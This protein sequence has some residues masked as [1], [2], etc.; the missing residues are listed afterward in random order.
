MYCSATEIPMV[1]TP[2][3]FNGLI[4]KKILQVEK[5]LKEKIYE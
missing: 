2:G 5:K 4:S 1:L 3:V